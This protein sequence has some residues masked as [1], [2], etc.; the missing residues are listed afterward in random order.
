V[1]QIC[2]VVRFLERFGN[3]E[4]EWTEETVTEFIEIY[5]G[6]EIIWEPKHPLNFNKIRNRDAWE[7]LGKEMNRL[8]DEC[9]TT[10]LS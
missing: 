8:V 6:K 3:C 5:K 10:N 2:S 1:V 7:E 4:M 9:V